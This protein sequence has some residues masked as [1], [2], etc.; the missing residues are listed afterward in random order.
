M[1]DKTPPLLDNI[2]N[3]LI[4]CNFDQSEGVNPNVVEKSPAVVRRYSLCYNLFDLIMSAFA[5]GRA[6]RPRTAA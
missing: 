1:A 3:I 5:D 2:T 4:Q 6:V